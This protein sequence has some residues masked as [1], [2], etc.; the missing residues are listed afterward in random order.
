MKSIFKML[1]VLWAAL[2]ISFATLANDGKKVVML[3]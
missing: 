2:S 1:L 3:K